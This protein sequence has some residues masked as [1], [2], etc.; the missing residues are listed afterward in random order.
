MRA[1]AEEEAAAA[2][3][4]AAAMETAACALENGRVRG[5]GGGVEAERPVWEVVGLDRLWLSSLKY[6]ISCCLRFSMCS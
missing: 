6:S 1:V 4:D 3:A 2:A 5:M